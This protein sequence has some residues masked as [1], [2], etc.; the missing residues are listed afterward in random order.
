M[1]E[2]DHHAHHRR[3]HRHRLIGRA[4]TALITGAAL[5]YAHRVVSQWTD[6]TT[7]FLSA[8]G[9]IVLLVLLFDWVLDLVGPVLLRFLGSV[10]KTTAHALTTDPEVVRLARRYPRLFAWMRRRLTLTSPR[11]LYRTLTVLAA[12]L[13]LWGFIAIAFGIVTSGPITGYDPQIA[14]LFE[15]FRT[16]GLTRFFWVF[17][18]LGDVRVAL[19]LAMLVIVLLELWSHRRDALFFAASVGGGA[20]L[21]ALAKLLFQRARPDAALALVELPSSYSFPS[22]HALYSM[23]ITFSLAFVMARSAR[24]FRARILWYGIAAFF[25]LLTALSRVYLGVHW[26]S[27]TIAA[28]MLGFSWLSVCIGT[29]VT[30][31]RYSGKG[32]ER[33][34]RD[35]PGIRRIITVAAVAVAALT[36]LWGAQ[37][38]PLLAAA[39]KPPEVREWQVTLAADGTPMPTAKEAEALP[40]WGENVNGTRMNPI[41]LIFV[42]TEK[43]LLKAFDDAGWQVAEHPGIA[44]SARGLVAGVMDRPYPTAP[45]SPAFMNGRVH[46][47]AFQKAY[48]EE[49]ARRRHHTR[50]WKTDFTL[51]GVPVWVATASLDA[52][53]AMSA[54]LI[55]PTHRIDPDIDAEQRYIVDSLEEGGAARSVS[56]VRVTK[57]TT[58][59]NAA[60]D[61]WFTQGE[62]T[63]LAAVK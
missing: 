49:S 10:I 23:L 57:P 55:M 5:V 1:H 19:P 58:G 37:R 52:G 22:G 61:R 54:T 51:E 42:G 41:G 11:G 26:M 59:T 63:V 13:F 31:E 44:S 27:D 15:A 30:Y 4:S 53:V 16:P 60:G 62:A 21:G 32:R 34:T 24:T 33:A 43:E 35:R 3:V 40:R 50:W 48:G 8:V 25:T 45:V 6:R 18:V 56:T 39:T 12:A 36:V 2:F 46:D 14:A 29:L 20:A 9:L 7:V 38:D 28:W 47:V 17:T